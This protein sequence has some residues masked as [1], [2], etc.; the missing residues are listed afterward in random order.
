[1]ALG[2]AELEALLETLLRAR[3]SGQRSVQFAD[4]SITWGS[5]EE[6]AGKSRALQADIARTGGATV[7]RTSYVS[8]ER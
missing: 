8:H 7:Y 3:Y 1:M 2:T 4:R 5:D 6:L